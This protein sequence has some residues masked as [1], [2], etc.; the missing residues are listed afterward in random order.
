MYPN[1]WKGLFFIL[2]GAVRISIGQ[3]GF[4]MKEQPVQF[5][6]TEIFRFGD[7]A[8]RKAAISRIVD[9]YLAIKLR[10]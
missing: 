4:R 9:R 7:P 3:G 1:L 10:P 2:L 8:A 5:A 6:V